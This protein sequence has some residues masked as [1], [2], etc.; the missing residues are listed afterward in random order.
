MNIEYK[1]PWFNVS[2][3]FAMFLVILLSLTSL[4]GVDLLV[5]KK[6]VSKPISEWG[7]YYYKEFFSWIIIKF[8]YY[9]S[10][11]FYIKNPI[12]FNNLI[13]F[14]LVSFSLRKYKFKGVFVSLALISPVGVLLSHNVLRQY[15]SCIFLFIFIINL[16]E[17]NLIFSVFM[18]LASILSHNS[19][20]FFVILLYSALLLNSRAGSVVFI[21]FSFMLLSLFSKIIGINPI[22]NEMTHD[23]LVVDGRIKYF[24][25]VSLTIIMYIFKN[26]TVNLGGVNDS[27]VINL[28]RY[29]DLM[30]V[31][32]LGFFLMDPP[33][34]VLSRLVIS[35]SF[36]NILCIIFI[37]H[38]KKIDSFSF[39]IFYVVLMTSSL[40]HPG[41]RSILFIN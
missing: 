24:S 41:V 5:Y 31:V 14:C 12:F 8:S 28:S 37:A 40:I 15:I 23:G 22:F 2:L 6:A 32:A 33:Y 10:D 17:R 21:I 19:S 26:I 36:V 27:I 1:K 38:Y 7:F 16:C 30:I 18:G 13:V 39:P 3:F 29:Y 35:A 4:G 20:I 11:L 34:W 9:L 25:Y